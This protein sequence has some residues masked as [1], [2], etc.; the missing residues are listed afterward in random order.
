[1]LSKEIMEQLRRSKALEGVSVFGIISR[2]EFIDNLA[3]YWT[4]QKEDRGAIRKSYQA[5]RKLGG[6]KG[7]KIPA[8]PIDDLL[9]LSAEDLAHE[10]VLVLS[11]ESPRCHAER[12]YIGQLGRQA[13][14]YTVAQL[15]VE[16]FPELE[17]TLLPKLKQN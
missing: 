5:M 10:F 1:M 4:A 8:H 3:A 7:M 16:E 11:C 6:A 15:L 14:N 13:Y 12:E 17:E 2:R 9:D